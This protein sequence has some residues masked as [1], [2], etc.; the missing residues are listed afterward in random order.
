[1]KNTNSSRE[2]SEKT[3]NRFPPHR[4]LFSFLY[5]LFAAEL[6]AQVQLKTVQAIDGS[7]G[8]QVEIVTSAPVVPVIQQLDAPPR[9]V[10]D[11]PNTRFQGKPQRIRV[12]RGEIKTIR[13]DEHQDSPPVARV[14]VDLSVPLAYK[15]ESSGNRLL[16]RFPREQKSVAQPPAH[17]GSP[18][19]SPGSMTFSGNPVPAGSSLTA[20]SDAAIL[21]LGRGGEV[22]VCPGTTLSV[23]PS[24]NGQDMMLGINTGA[25][26]A[27]YALQS[28]S[29]S[30][31]TPDFRILLTGPGK[32]DVAIG[33]DA[34][35]N[36]CVEALPG[37]TASV[38]MTELMGDQTYQVRPT[39]QVLFHAGHISGAE[40]KIP[41]TCGCPAPVAPIAVAGPESK[42][43]PP[44]K[45][46]DVHV[47]V[48][49]PF[50]FNANGA[51]PASPVPTA[52]GPTQRET[53][54]LPVV[55]IRRA[56]PLELEYEVH[57]P[58][59]P[60]PPAPTNSDNKGFLGKIKGFLG[61][62]FR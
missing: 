43:L 4:W 15:T 2:S 32:F 19:L 16:V 39:E 33:A 7:D 54:E 56:A 21:H 24:P 25:L 31:L 57:A 42:P 18:S 26:E 3:L 61:K 5:V 46:N 41:S 14:V 13:V 59:Q 47:T 28:S 55:N 50:V 20:G 27:H 62:I 30:V 9:L 49:A 6:C 37:D 40:S 35:G 10:V 58:P 11:F 52:Q 17:T 45:P 12:D 29:D 48:D 1:L 34:H 22:R 36:T 53:E 38:T 51:A 60:P 8:P 23:T 44:S